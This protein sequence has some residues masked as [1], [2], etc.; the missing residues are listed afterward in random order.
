[1][2]PAKYM[3]VIKAI[4]PEIFVAVADEVRRAALVD[5]NAFE[6]VTAQLLE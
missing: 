1:V 5:N 6:A 3:E 4:Q 2:T